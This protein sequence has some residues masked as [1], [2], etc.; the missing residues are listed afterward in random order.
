MN[1][2]NE[3]LINRIVHL[4][5]TDRSTDAP[6]DAIRWS[7]NLFR[8]R[9]DAPERSVVQKILAALQIDL[10]PGKAA[11]GERSAAPAQTRQMLFSAGENSIDLRITKTE[12]GFDLRGQ[13]MGDGFGNCAIELGKFETASN[14]LS[15]FSFSE[16]PAGVYDLTVRAGE[17]EIVIEN[18]EIG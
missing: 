12:K 2:G 11:F 5:E 17:A 3:N 10:A 16:I 9:A 7:K 6:P 1:T 15:E 8:A 4:M 18:L 14:E 13:I